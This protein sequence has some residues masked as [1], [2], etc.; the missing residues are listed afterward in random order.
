MWADTG[1]G[2]TV[3]GTRPMPARTV[4][5]SARQPWTDSG[6][7]VRVGDRITVTPSGMIRYAPSQGDRVDPAGGA[8][9]ATAAAPRPDLPIGALIGRVGNGQP[10]LIGRGLEAM[11]ITE[12]GRL[13]LGTND[14]ILTD[15]DGQFR[16]VV[17]ITRRATQ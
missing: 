7:D 15:N 14:D 3:L 10:F 13:F 16:A 1:S 17:T 6:I 8:N 4:M 11:R 5:V 12:N 9:N 2:G